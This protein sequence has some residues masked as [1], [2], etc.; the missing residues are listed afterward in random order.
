MCVI[1]SATCS[2][3]IRDQS[4]IVYDILK[5]NAE[6]FL[7]LISSVTQPCYANMP[8][9]YPSK[10]LLRLTWR[11]NRFMTTRGPQMNRMFT[12]YF[13]GENLNGTGLLQSASKIQ[14]TSLK[15]THWHFIYNGSVE[16]VFK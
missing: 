12:R 15:T 9:K 13:Y 3:Q 16:I 14:S 11:K 2:D 4:F 1:Y 8:Y 10:I 6:S 5:K 7:S